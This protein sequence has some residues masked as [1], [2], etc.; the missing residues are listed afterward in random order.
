M[1]KQKQEHFSFLELPAEIRNL[2]YDRVN[3]NHSLDTQQTS[4]VFHLKSHVGR[5]VGFFPP[6]LSWASKQT[7]SECL[8]LLFAK[9]GS[10]INVDFTFE[11]RMNTNTKRW[12]KR[13]AGHCQDP[14]ALCL[15]RNP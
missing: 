6:R 9:E 1:Q 7:R 12:V 8:S 10:S 15:L 5:H 4:Y 13:L 3:I 14:E 2:I 11:G